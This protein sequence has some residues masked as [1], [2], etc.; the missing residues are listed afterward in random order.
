MYDVR[1]MMYE[2]KESLLSPVEGRRR[3]N[4][5]KYGVIY[6]FLAYGVLIIEE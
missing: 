1:C 6:V 4:G 3:G 5:L 2:V